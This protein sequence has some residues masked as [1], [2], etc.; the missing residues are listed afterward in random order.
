VAERFYFTQLLQ[1]LL[2]LIQR[3]KFQ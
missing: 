1:A 3:F 2:K